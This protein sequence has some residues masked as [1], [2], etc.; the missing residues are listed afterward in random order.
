MACKECV[1]SE[2][3]KKFS[4]PYTYDI[5][6]SIG[7]DDFMD[8]KPHTNADRIRAMSDEEL[9]EFLCSILDCYTDKC[10]GEDYCSP[11]GNGCFVWLK[12]PAE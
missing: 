7:C 5:L 4:D 8:R 3:C 2:L 9:A 1:H 10:P 12:R 6:P 11:D